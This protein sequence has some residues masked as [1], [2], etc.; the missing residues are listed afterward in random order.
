MLYKDEED[1]K[2]K[3]NLDKDE[4]FAYKD[5]FKRIK[6]NLKIIGI[7]EKANIKKFRDNKG[8]GWRNIKIMKDK[9]NKK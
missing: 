7:K 9:K 3:D 5:N 8:W 2:N 4:D 6:I 1:N